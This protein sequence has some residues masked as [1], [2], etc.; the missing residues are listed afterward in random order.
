MKTLTLFGLFYSLTSIATAQKEA[1]RIQVTDAEIPRSVVESFNRDFKG[2]QAKEWAIV[3]MELV[4]REYT[5]RENNYP[6]ERPTSYAVRLTGPTISGEVIYD[7]N[8]DFKYCKEIIR[9]TMLPLVVVQAV[10]K[11]YAGYYFLK[12]QEFIRDGMTNAD[13]YRVAIVK[14]ND[15]VV[16]AV[17]PSGKVLRVR[18]MGEK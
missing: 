11:K 10:D 16:L 7:Q 17:D 5:V 18:N 9:N 2:S 6:G 4:G 15:K 14:G 1:L 8:G 3:P 13:F 12:D